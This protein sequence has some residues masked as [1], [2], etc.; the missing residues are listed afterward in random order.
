LEDNA[1]RIEKRRPIKNINFGLLY[2]QGQD[3]L[4]YKA[5][6]SKSAA[7]TFFKAY[8]QGS[9]YVKA[10]MKAISDE[11]QLNGFI[12]TILNRRCRFNLWEPSAWD[13]RGTALPYEQA[14][15]NYGSQIRRAYDYKGT[16]YKFQGS[17]A[18]VIKNAMAT[19]ETDGVFEVIGDP[20]I[21][22]H[23]EL[24]FSIADDS[25]RTT[26]ALRHL[27]DIMENSTPCSV[28]IKVDNDSG[29][30]WGDIK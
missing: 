3:E 29:P 1:L 11:V 7:V 17:A 30:T 4:A 12:T 2:G 14:I 6:L 26:E 24:D 9:P 23:D 15:L 25:P 27:Y 19:A 10:T 5:G 18:D 16:N 20:L 8:H 22:V 21:Q 28:P 13:R